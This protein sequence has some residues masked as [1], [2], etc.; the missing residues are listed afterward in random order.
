MSV[1]KI[2][3]IEDGFIFGPATVSR[4]GDF[5]KWGYVLQVSTARQRVDIRVTPSGI[6]R[7]EQVITRKNG[8]RYFAGLI[9]MLSK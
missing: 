9:K 6:I 4:I 5:G 3:N 7:V 1:S 8:S 2:K